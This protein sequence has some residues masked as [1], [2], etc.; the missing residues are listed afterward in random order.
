MIAGPVADARQRRSPSR[1]PHS[2]RIPVPAIVRRLRSS[3]STIPTP[4]ARADQARCE[5]IVGAIAPPF[6]FVETAAA[7]GAPSTRCTSRDWPRIHGH[8]FDRQLSATSLNARTTETE[9][10][11]ACIVCDHDLDFRRCLRDT[12]RVNQVT[13]IVVVRD[14]PTRDV[15]SARGLKYRWW[16]LRRRLRPAACKRGTST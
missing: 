8:G 5:P 7:C 9:S 3:R 12:C 16:V 4:R 10:V 1:P 6:R 15:S 14:H 11:R 2:C 13:R